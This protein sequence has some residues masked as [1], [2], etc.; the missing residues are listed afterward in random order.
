MTL[1]DIISKVTR[2]AKKIIVNDTSGS[3]D[4]VSIT[5]TSGTALSL[6][7]NNPDPNKGGSIDIFP[8]SGGE[9]VFNGGADG[10]FVFNNS[11]LSATKATTFS[12]AEVGI[13]ATNPSARLHV[14]GSDS[15]TAFIVTNKKDNAKWLVRAESD[16]VG[17]ESGI[18][19]D[20]SNNMLFDSRNGTGNLTVSIKSSGNSYLN[21]GNVGIGTFG[22]SATLHVNGTVRL[23]QATAGSATAGASGATPAQVAG[24]LIVNIN[25]TDKKIP[26]YNT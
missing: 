25:G 10:V 9:F 4:A 19:V 17:N 7:Q 1:T 13:S 12:G 5:N 24:Y 14:N 23:D 26:F 15:S 2:Y 11:S 20:A 3:G 8:P 21:G 16:T 6:Q 18:Y 22:P